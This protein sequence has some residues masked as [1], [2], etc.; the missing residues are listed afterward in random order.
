MGPAALVLVEQAVAGLV[1]TPLLQET[2]TQ[3]EEAEVVRVIQMALLAALVLSSS[4]SHLRISLRS[5]RA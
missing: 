5:H 2:Q 4:K 1:E 3:E